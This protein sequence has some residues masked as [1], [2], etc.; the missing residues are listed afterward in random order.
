MLYSG[1]DPESY[2][3]ECSFVY[4]DLCKGLAQIEKAS[5]RP[6]R[7]FLRRARL[8]R[9]GPLGPDSSL[10]APAQTQPRNLSA[11]TQPRNLSAQTQPRWGCIHGGRFGSNQ[12]LSVSLSLA[13][14][15]S[16]DL[17]IYLSHSLFDTS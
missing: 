8:S 2:I 14:S 10:E 6:G 12:G 4:E 5:A 1:I 13:R 9:G 17:S 11:Q 16:I 15:L 7:C 3:T